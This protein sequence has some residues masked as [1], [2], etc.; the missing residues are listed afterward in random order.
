VV[1]ANELADNL[2]F[3]VAVHDGGWRLATVAERDG[4]LVEVL[5]PLPADVA[6]LAACLPASARHGA[7]A[8]L[9]TGAAAW[10]RDALARSGRV[11]LIDYAAPSAELAGRAW[12][13]WLRTY[14]G[15]ERGE[16]PLVAPGSQDI[17]T[18]VPLDQLA[19][20]VRAPD[21]VR[22]QTAF[23][24]AHGIG[25]LVAEGKRVWAERAH[26]GDLAALRMRS[27]LREGDALTD[28]D[29]LGGFTVAEWIGTA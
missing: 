15:H 28:P 12:R 27:R 25:D 21:R 8:P 3:D 2:P 16:H 7:R 18:D 1:V 9:A 24:A 5:G 6:P 13:D 22:S 17:T 14:R 10:L 19:A 20:A 26:V 4:R 29:G 23:L 11:V